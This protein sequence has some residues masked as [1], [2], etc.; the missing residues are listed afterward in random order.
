MIEMKSSPLLLHSTDK[1][2]RNALY[3]KILIHSV[4]HQARDINEFVSHERTSWSPRNSDVASMA[5][6]LNGCFV[7]VGL[8]RRPAQSYCYSIKHKKEK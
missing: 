3:L 4:R 8:R 7:Q 2:M 1:M 6:V 5:F